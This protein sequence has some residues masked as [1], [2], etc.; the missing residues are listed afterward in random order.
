VSGHHKICPKSYGTPETHAFRVLAVTRDMDGRDLMA[1][2]L[3]VA[4][5]PRG[6]QN[7][8][9]IMTERRPWIDARS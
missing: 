2:V 1:E 8:I 9:A 7:R 6:P 5:E 3:N 4:L